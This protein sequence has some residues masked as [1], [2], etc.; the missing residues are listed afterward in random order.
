MLIQCIV[1]N[2]A[3]PRL[4]PV[5]HLILDV[6]NRYTQADGAVPLASPLL[7]GMLKPVE[8]TKKKPRKIAKHT[9]VDGAYVDTTVDEQ[10]HIV[11]SSLNEEQRVSAKR[12]LQGGN[13]FITG[14]A[15]TGKSYLLKYL[16]QELAHKHGNGR[17]AVTAPTGVAAVNIGGQTLHYFSGIGLGNGDRNK[18]LA[19]LRKSPSAVERWQ[20][21]EVLII[22]EISMLDKALFET[23]DCIARSI[24]GVNLPFGGMQ[25]L[26]VGDFL[27]LPPIGPTADFCFKSNVWDDCGLSNTENIVFLRQMCRQTDIEFMR[28]LNEVRQGRISDELLHCLDRCLVDKKQRP[29]DGID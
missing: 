21:T 8:V 13:F 25:L 15:G 26:L 22:D 24:R 5:G 19:T 23:L 14:S 2:F 27:Q 16:I 10:K 6:V 28:I 3:Q 17:V 20:L 12:I 7:A 1:F 4:Q 29:N 18:L 9:A 11:L